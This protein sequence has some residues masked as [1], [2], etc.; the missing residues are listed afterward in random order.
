DGTI[1]RSEFVNVYHARLGTSQHQAEGTF[2]AI[3]LNHDGTFDD[4]EITAVYKVFDAN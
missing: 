1:T 4:K 3:D 2:D